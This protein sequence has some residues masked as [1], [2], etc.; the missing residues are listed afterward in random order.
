MV[1]L[2]NKTCF[3]DDLDRRNLPG[4]KYLAP[5]IT[6][7]AITDDEAF[8]VCGELS[9]NGFHPLCAAARDDCRGFCVVDFFE[10]A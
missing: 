10:G 3:M 7:P 2:L 8:L 1:T 6:K 4:F 5:T 9:G